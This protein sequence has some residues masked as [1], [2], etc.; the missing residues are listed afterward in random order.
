MCA[1]IPQVSK[2][3]LQPR[4]AALTLRYF[5]DTKEAFGYYIPI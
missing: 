2:T 5:A 3:M 4:S 1:N